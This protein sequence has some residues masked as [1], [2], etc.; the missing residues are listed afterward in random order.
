MVP[1]KRDLR[2]YYQLFGLNSPSL[3]GEF[4]FKCFDS[5]AFSFVRLGDLVAC[6]KVA[7]TH[8]L[9][10]SGSLLLAWLSERCNT[11]FDKM[12]IFKDEKSC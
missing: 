9:S 11:F 3:D 8:L 7:L 12:K 4:N 5:C 1:V 10:V 2:D 6:T